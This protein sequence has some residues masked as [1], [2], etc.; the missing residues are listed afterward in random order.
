MSTPDPGTPIVIEER[1]G[2]NMEQSIT[3][4]GW[5]PAVQES[6]TWQ[7]EGMTAL[8]SPDQLVAVVLDQGVDDEADP[9]PARCALGR[10]D[11]TE[12]A[13]LGTTYKAWTEEQVDET[14]ELLD[15]AADTLGELSTMQAALVAYMTAATQAWILTAAAVPVVLDDQLTAMAAE[16]TVINGMATPLATIDSQLAT[17]RSNILSHKGDIGD[18]LSALVTVASE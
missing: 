4:V 15:R 3:W 13:V 14:V 8:V 17:L 18:H 5:T 2:A 1:F 6:V 12:K 7:R 10:H 9:E 16:L 11:A